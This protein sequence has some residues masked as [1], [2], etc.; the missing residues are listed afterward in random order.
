MSWVVTSSS[1]PAAGKSE[2]QIT[3]Q[4]GRAYS[5]DE[6]VFN[7]YGPK[8]NAELILGYGFA[9]EDNP[10]DSLVLKLGGQG[11]SGTRH[12]IQQNGENLDAVYEELKGI[13]VQNSAEEEEP[14]EEWEVELEVADLLGEM[15]SAMKEKIWGALPRTEG[16]A[17]D[18]ESGIRAEVLKMIQIYISGQARLVGEV[19]RRVEAM[20]ESAVKTAREH[21]A[22]IEE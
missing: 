12:E 21:G 13:N 19:E 14:P 10:E 5:K 18:R 16:T 3:L 15:V 22:V 7:N 2:Y 17:T 20:W 1:S 4:N 8:S 9:L 6:Q 11:V